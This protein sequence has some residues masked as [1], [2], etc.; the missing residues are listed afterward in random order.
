[1]KVTVSDGD[2][3]KDVSR[4][5][6]KTISLTMYKGRIVKATFTTHKEDFWLGH[7]VT[8]VLK[9]AR[10]LYKRYKIQARAKLQEVNLSEK[11]GE[12]E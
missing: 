1:M 8:Q 10:R 3:P 4:E 2:I 6:R 12:N 7:E 9:R 11:E 5:D